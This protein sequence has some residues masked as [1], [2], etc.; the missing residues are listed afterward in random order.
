MLG[1]ELF[2]AVYA[3]LKRLA[4]RA[5]SSGRESDTLEPTGLVHEVWLRL[6]Q[7]RQAPRHG[8]THFIALGA[9]AMRRVLA[10]HG[11][12][13]R[14]AKRGAGVAAVTLHDWLDVADDTRGAMDDAID[15]E[16]VLARL[17]AVDSRQA[18]IV[19]M[20]FFGGLTVPEVARALGISARTVEA[21]WT[22]AR[23]WLRR[24]LAGLP[25]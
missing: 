20:R 18:E 19:R 10:D 21:E 3:E 13:R 14:R 12:G 23:A 17:A 5:L 25:R 11:R 2:P 16:G 1:A 9:L 15:V 7:D 6:Q 22:H 4:R 8:R 24:E